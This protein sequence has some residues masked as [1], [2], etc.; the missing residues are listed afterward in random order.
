MNQ[1]GYI[2]NLV[3]S[4][5][6]WS[7]GHVLQPKLVIPLHHDDLFGSYGEVEQNPLMIEFDRS[8]ASELQQSVLPA[9]LKQ[10]RFAEPV[11]IYA[12]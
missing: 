5:G 7:N 6:T 3:P 11:A 8:S 10:M 4:I 9:K 12:E 2:I 1:T